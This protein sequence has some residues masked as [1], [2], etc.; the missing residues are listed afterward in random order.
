MRYTLSKFITLLL[1]RLYILTV[2]N[3]KNESTLN[4]IFTLISTIFFLNAFSQKDI[5]LMEY[6]SSECEE[7]YFENINRIN[8]RIINTESSN[9]ISSINVFT[10]TNCNDTEIGEIEIK[11]DTS[12]LIYHIKGYYL[13]PVTKTIINND[14]IQVTEKFTYIEETSECDCAYKLNYK[15]KNLDLD[16][17]I[18]TLNGRRIEKSEHQFKVLKDKP[19]FEIVK[20]DTINL[21]DIYGLKQKLHIKYRKDGKLHSKVYYENGEKVSGLAMVFYDFKDF[22]RVETFI[23]NK[24]FTK[25]KYYSKGKLIK[26]CDTEGDFEEGTNC[27][28]EK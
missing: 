19:T 10:K 23:E 12:N 28:F 11:G 17:Y 20:G 26:T 16:N 9:G 3:N 4:K 7:V 25:R 18:I 5:K 24:K 22:D 6:T 15:I 2:S 21:I 1:A 14:S 27:T 8:T 13:E